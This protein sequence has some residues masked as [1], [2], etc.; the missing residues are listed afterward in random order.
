MQ[1]D[2]SS[3][4]LDEAAFGAASLTQQTLSGSRQMLGAMFDALPVALL[5]HTEQGVLLA[6]R[7]AGSLLGN[8][9]RELVGQHFM[10]FV[11]P[12]DSDVM[13]DV[14]HRSFAEAGS[15][16]RECA[17]QRADGSRRLISV[18]C[19]RLPWPG[20]PVTQILCRDITDQ[21]RAEASLRQLTITD[22]L[23]GAYNRRHAFYEASLY[24]DR[25][26]S[27]VPLSI[28]LID[29]D[30]FKHINDTFGHAAGDLALKALT[31]LA[32]SFLPLHREANSAMFARLGGE[33][34]LMLLPGM[35][36]GRAAIVSDAFR[37][38][39]EC[40]SVA[41][42]SAL[43]RFTLSAGVATSSQADQNFDAL[44]ARADTALY[45]AKSGGRNKVVIASDVVSAKE[46]EPRRTGGSVRQ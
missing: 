32:N 44:L 40:A 25:S 3:F 6:N 2:F 36:A 18:I 10:D 15:L 12:E 20:I 42:G 23:T 28:A 29:I 43:L 9:E 35:D 21:K 22:E 26:R 38:A 33:E 45:A 14:F 30:H 31:T 7:E 34:F 16:Q 4:D 11:A 1:E 19:G 8:A 39:V 41:S 24:L 13:W 37:Q 17:L 46:P 27:H 5:I